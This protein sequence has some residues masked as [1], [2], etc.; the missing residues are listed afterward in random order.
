MSIV[1]PGRAEVPLYMYCRE[2]PEYPCT[3]TV[4]KSP[5]TLVHV[6]SERA[7]VPLYMYCRK[8]PEYP[9][10]C[11]AG[12]S[13]STLVHVLPG[14]ALVHVLLGRALV[15]VLLGG[16]LVHVL[17]GRA[18]VLLYMYCR[19]EPE[20]LSTPVSVHPHSVIVVFSHTTLVHT[21]EDY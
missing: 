21:M 13:P 12:K 9:C 17:P 16:A 20:T 6:L 1:L 2:E 11:T 8:E 5:S 10:T 15:H 14:R 4:G 18:R 7:R 3:C 19:E